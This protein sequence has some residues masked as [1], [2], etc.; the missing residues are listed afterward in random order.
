MKD[1]FEFD[2]DFE[3]VVSPQ[4]LTLLPFVAVLDK[5]KNK[6]I[7][8]AELSYICFLCDSKSEYSDIRD[9]KERSS[10]ILSS[11]I[12]GNEIKID[13]VTEKAIEFYKERSHTT[14]TI[15]LDSALNA[16]DKLSKYFDAINFEERDF[17]GN[18]VYDPKKV[19][20]V[21][22]ATP[23]LMAGLREVRDAIKKEQEV[24]GNIRGSGKKG[25]YED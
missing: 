22:S 18:L 8:I 24:E 12:H 14:T 5:Y 9:E 2:E 4:A 20:D 21:I 6:K 17:K 10:A 1:L 3:V 13:K 16:I 11:I 7:G 25:I 19:T 15:F 23:K